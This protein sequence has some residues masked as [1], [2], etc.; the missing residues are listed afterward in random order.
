MPNNP[1]AS[2]KNAVTEGN[3]VGRLR[4]RFA[5]LSP[6]VCVIAAFASGWLIWALSPTVT[7]QREPWDSTFWYYSASLFLAGLLLSAP[8]L[9][10]FWLV[11][12]ALIA[13]QIAFIEFN[14]DPSVAVIF[15]SFV[16]VPVFATIPAFAGAICGFGLQKLFEKFF[17]DGNSR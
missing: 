16:A 14:N 7:G 10:L 9:R 11:P 4:A 17:F 5:R 13:G 8:C 15:P 2:P 3:S 1:Y 6:L 12:I